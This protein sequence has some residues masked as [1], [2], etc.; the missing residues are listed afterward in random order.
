LDPAV[1]VQKRET[2]VMRAFSY[3]RFGVFVLFP[4]ISPQLSRDVPANAGF[5]CG[6]AA[7][8]GWG[9]RKDPVYLCLHCMTI[10]I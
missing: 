6:K 4:L 9:I 5:L 8:F 3:L 7:V 2:F 10:L 1:S